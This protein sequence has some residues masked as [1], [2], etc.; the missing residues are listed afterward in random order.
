MALPD[1]NQNIAE[2]EEWTR[3]RASNLSLA[4]VF[5][6]VALVLFLIAIWKYRPL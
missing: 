3:R 6:G 2:S 4:L 5:G 1:S